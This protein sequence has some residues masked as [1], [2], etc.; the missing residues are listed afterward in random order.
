M[1][2]KGNLGAYRLVAWTKTARSNKGDLPPNANW[3]S[4]FDGIHSLV[5]FPEILNKLTEVTLDN[6]SSKFDHFINNAKYLTHAPKVRIWS[7]KG[8][9][10][11]MTCPTLG[12]SASKAIIWPLEVSF[13]PRNE[14]N[15]T[16]K[17]CYHVSKEKMKQK[18]GGKNRR[19]VVKNSF[20]TSIFSFP[21]IVKLRESLI[22]MLT[23][24]LGLRFIIYSKYR[25]RIDNVEHIVST[26]SEILAALDQY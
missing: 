1:A 4:S 21:S 16:W 18:K 22:R 23:I 26:I 9:M 15:E 10:I 17:Y 3:L 14:K 8:L 20:Q 5:A 13:N 6:R 25:I 19:N 24:I 11:T 2:F 7:G 12:H